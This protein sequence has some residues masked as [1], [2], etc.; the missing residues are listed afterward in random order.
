MAQNTMYMNTA[1]RNRSEKLPGQR[2]SVKN[3][4]SCGCGSYPQFKEAVNIPGKLSSTCL[5]YHRSPHI[6]TFGE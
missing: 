5:G 2:E 1:Q 4:F 3:R 6:A